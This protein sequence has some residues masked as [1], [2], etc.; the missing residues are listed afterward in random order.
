MRHVFELMMKTVVALLMM[1]HWIH[2][3][4]DRLSRCAKVNDNDDSPGCWRHDVVLHHSDVCMEPF[5]HF[6]FAMLS[7]S[8]CVQQ[9]CFVTL[10]SN[11]DLARLLQ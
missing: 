11:Y 6:N 5:Q 8:E 2:V 10:K 9:S 1:M 4:R 7:G 3:I